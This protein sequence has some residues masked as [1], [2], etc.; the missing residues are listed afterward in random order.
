[1]EKHKID[2]YEKADYQT[3]FSDQYLNSDRSIKREYMND[4]FEFHIKC[5]LNE[6]GLETIKGFWSIQKH[7]L[8]RDVIVRLALEVDVRNIQDI[9]VLK[10]IT[11]QVKM[12]SEYSICVYV[13]F[14]LDNE[15]NIRLWKELRGIG[16]TQKIVFEIRKNGD[17]RKYFNEMLHNGKIK[18]KYKKIYVQ[19]RI[20]FVRENVDETLLFPYYLLALNYNN[21]KKLE[22]YLQD[23]KTGDDYYR[24][25]TYVYIQNKFYHG[26]GEVI[27]QNKR[28]QP[29]QRKSLKA[30]FRLMPMLTVNSNGLKFL[31]QP[32]EK[33]WDRI[34]HFDEELDS[35]EKILLGICNRLLLGNIGIGNAVLNEIRK[36]VFESSQF[37]S[38]V[39]S[40]PLLALLIFAIMDHSFREDAVERYKECIRESKKQAGETATN[41]RLAE[42][43]FLYEMQ[44]RQ[45]RS[46]YE[47]YQHVVEIGYDNKT[48]FENRDRG[49]VHPYIVKELYEAIMVSEGVLQLLENIV[50]HVDE[51]HNGR[52]LFSLH[53]R[54]VHDIALQ[55]TY[56][57]YRFKEIG[58]T[59]YLELMIQDMSGSNI[60]AKFKDNN[61][62]FIEENLHA[63]SENYLRWED[64]LPNTFSLKS[65]FRPN[66]EE[67]QFWN[68]FFSLGDKAVNHYGLQIFDSIISSKRGYFEV[69]SGTE[70]YD[71][72]SGKLE[73]VDLKGGTKY[74]ILWPLNNV[75]S[76]D[77]N[78]YDSMFGYGLKKYVY[79]RKK[80]RKIGLDWQ[81]ELF[82]REGYIELTK[83]IFEDV[84]REE[85]EKIFVIDI[86]KVNDLENFLKGMLLFIFQKKR[87]EEKCGEMLFAM[88]NCKTYQIIDIVRIISL[89]YDKQGKNLR[90]EDVQIY[91][92]GNK[93]GEEILFY[94]KE[95]LEVKNNIAK[96][97]CM[98]GTM[99]ENL[100]TIDRI[101][102]GRE[103]DGEL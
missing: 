101:L 36:E 13:V 99:Y 2:I 40:V 97:A 21:I 62:R 55:K 87:F 25:S 33:Y 57:E 6:E 100:Q 74:T 46:I 70:K 1:M 41:V 68:I 76:Q 15:K 43:D 4:T 72:Q 93:V 10:K 17:Y 60:P 30:V 11:L 12:H 77:N 28:R 53:I 24:I 61:C 16:H 88:L 22:V 45:K 3:N 98:R 79:E 102:R 27:Y 78:I 85:G 95:L 73:S 58:A 44:S 89:Y 18:D 91:I 50:Y 64:V 47:V 34:L 92:R 20:F 37:E 52:G 29:F 94:G 81:E 103:S 5:A 90:M 19:F 8:Y 35:E 69:V 63:F 51:N 39:Q 42:A 59:Y 14:G 66:N 9:E 32:A 26:K 82:S 86:Q 83:K 67:T 7:P 49:T 71:N 75:I 80:T 65:F 84:D 54:N 56:P 23:T 38:M 96:S 48:L 31:R